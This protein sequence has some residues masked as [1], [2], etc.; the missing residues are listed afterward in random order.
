MG[1]FSTSA[2]STSRINKTHHSTSPGG[3][4]RGSPLAQTTPESL[5]NGFCST[6]APTGLSSEVSPVEGGAPRLLF[7]LMIESHPVWAPPCRLLSTYKEVASCVRTS[8]LEDEIPPGLWGARL[9]LIIPIQARDLSL[10]R[11]MSLSRI[12]TLY[13]PSAPNRNLPHYELVKR[14]LRYQWDKLLA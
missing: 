14:G 1:S 13:I 8:G 6:P 7:V 9:R 4:T 3:T 11:V 2:S 10:A 12:H 5:A